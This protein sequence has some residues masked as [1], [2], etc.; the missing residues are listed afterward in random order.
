MSR[1]R[2]REEGVYIDYRQNPFTHKT[3]TLDFAIVVA[4]EIYRVLD[5]QETL[6]K[7]GDVC[8]QRAT[9][10][11]WSNR[12]GESCRMAFLLIDGEKV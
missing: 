1:R 3:E 2:T 6:M 8:V 12:S 11:V 9:N 5:G 10:H 7:A 4:G